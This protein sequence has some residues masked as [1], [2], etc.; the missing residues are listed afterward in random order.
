MNSTNLNSMN[1]EKKNHKAIFNYNYSSFIYKEIII[2]KILS[3]GEVLWDVYPDAAHL[4]GAPLN[5][6]AHLAL[7]GADAYF[8]SA[9][10]K[11]ELGEETVQEV[12]KLGV[13]TDYISVSDKETGKCLV[14]LDENAVPKY[15]LLTDVAYD[16]IAMPEFS[17]DDEFDAIA[18]GTLAL[19]MNNN[20]EVLK[21][22]IRTANYKEI[23]SD[24]NIRPPF[25]SDESISFCMSNA[26][27]VKISD[28]E[29]PTV[30]QSLLKKELDVKSAAEALSEAFGQLKLIIITCGAEGSCAYDCISKTFYEAPVVPVKVV[31]TVGAGDSFGAAFLYKYFNKEDIQSCLEYASKV[32]A[33]VVSHKDAIPKDLYNSL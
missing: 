4:G 5:F 7:Q 15:N 26:T 12:E 29:L 23:Y 19:R 6:A 9:V 28:E 27:I 30:T 1:S 13:K 31:S 14:T 22:I 8:V 25:Y 11:D 17:A 21:D 24:L 2:M 10:G 16:H 3:F 18:F 20:I 32:S 33:M